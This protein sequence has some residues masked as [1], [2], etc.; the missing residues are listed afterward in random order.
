VLTIGL[1]LAFL[2]GEG[3]HPSRLQAREW[4]GL[5]F[6]PVGILVGMIVA[7][8]HE[9]VGGLI[10]VGSL[11]VFYVIHF[12][13]AGIFPRGWA[14]L[15]FAVPGFLFVLTRVLQDGVRDKEA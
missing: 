2:V 1:V 8:R 15:V 11:A 6:F 4:L 12:V 9:L 13:T 5:I 7:W 14:F 3:F 10:T